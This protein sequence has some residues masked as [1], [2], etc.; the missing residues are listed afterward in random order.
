MTATDDI[1]MIV[2]HDRQERQ[3]TCYQRQRVL[4][5]RKF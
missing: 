5:T 1:K 4:H 2:T 3:K